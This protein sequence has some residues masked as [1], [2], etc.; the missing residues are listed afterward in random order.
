MI[1]NMVNGQW[2]YC[3]AELFRTTYRVD[4]LEY[5]SSY[6]TT[7]CKSMKKKVGGKYREIG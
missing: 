5:S 6:H 7:Y 2:S 1:H 4:I 3:I